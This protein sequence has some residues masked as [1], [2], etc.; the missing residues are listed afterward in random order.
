MR[1]AAELLLAA[2]ATAIALPRLPPILETLADL[3]FI[4]LVIVALALA[5]PFIGSAYRSAVLRADAP[6]YGRRE[7]ALSGHCALIALGVAI[8]RTSV[9]SQIAGPLALVGVALLLG[10]IMFSA[11]ARP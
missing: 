3:L 9:I 6:V 1:S 2:A 4:G 7:L 10:A 5:G 8:G 11:H